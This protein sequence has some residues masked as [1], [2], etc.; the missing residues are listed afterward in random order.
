[1]PTKADVTSTCLSTALYPDWIL[2]RTTKP[3]GRN[4]SRPYRTPR[5]GAH[6]DLTLEEELDAG[7]VFDPLQLASQSSLS[8]HQRSSTQDTTQGAE[9][10]KTAQDVTRNTPRERTSKPC[11]RI[12]CLPHCPTRAWLRPEEVGA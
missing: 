3:T 9:G 10:P 6:E 11:A 1:M 4:M 5:E 12:P 7:F 8:D 2:K